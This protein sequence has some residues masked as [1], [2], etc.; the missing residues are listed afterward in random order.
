ML[1]FHELLAFEQ[2]QFAFEKMSR[3]LKNK[4]ISGSTV[5]ISYELPGT[6]SLQ[7]AV[8]GERTAKEVLDDNS[9]WNLIF[10]FFSSSPDWLK[11]D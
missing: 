5:T 2:L 10:F 9:G 8:G 3:C 11:D 1:H 6:L 7:I 4:K